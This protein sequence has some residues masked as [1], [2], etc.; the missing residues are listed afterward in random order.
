MNNSKHP[1]RLWRKAHGLT[2]TQ[3]GRAI[4]VGVSQVSMIEAGR[5]GASVGTAI[6]IGKLT[7]GAVPLDS[8]LPTSRVVA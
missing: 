8:L 4:G 2:Q 3:L 6:K 5:R 7:G 1:L